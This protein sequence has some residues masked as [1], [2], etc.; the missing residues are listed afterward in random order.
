LNGKPLTGPITK[1]VSTIV[2]INVNG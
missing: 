2:A 1:S